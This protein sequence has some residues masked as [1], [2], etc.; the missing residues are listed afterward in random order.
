MFVC[1][2]DHVAAVRAG[3]GA[4]DQQQIVLGVDAARASGCG[5]SSGRCRSWPGIR[6]PLTTRL[7]NAL[8]AGAAQCPVALLHAVRGPLAGEVVPLAWRRRSRGPCE[9]AVTST[10][11]TLGE[12]VDVD[13]ARRR[14]DRRPGRGFRGRIASARSRPWRAARRRRRS[15]SSSACCRAW[16]HDRGRCDWPGGGA[17][18]R[19]P[20]CTAS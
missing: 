14:P 1:L 13:L 3:H 15:A 16:R 12:G 5:P 10:D 17:C 6:L 9:V 4:A 11:F 7:G 20:S 18:R 2:N 19:K 8:R